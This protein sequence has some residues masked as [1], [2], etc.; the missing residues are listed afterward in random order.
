[1]FIAVLSRAVPLAEN[2]FPG[3]KDSQVRPIRMGA[4]VVP[5]SLAMEGGPGWSGS[6]LEN[7]ARALILRVQLL[8]PPRYR[9]R[10]QPEQ[11]LT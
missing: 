4:G 5:A 2:G 8:H 6:G 11:E 1:M 10:H 7:R 3:L 9:H